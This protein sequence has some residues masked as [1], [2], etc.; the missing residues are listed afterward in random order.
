MKHVPKKAKLGKPKP[1]RIELDPRQLKAGIALPKIN[2]QIVASVEEEE[3]YNG[4]VLPLPR[5]LV[6]YLTRSELLVVA[7]I[8]EQSRDFGECAL[9]V[10]ELSARLRLSVPTMSNCLYSLRK[11]G[12]LLEMPDGKRGAGRIRKLNY[13]AIQHLNDLCEDEDYGIY[14]RIRKAT[15]KRDILNLTKEDIKKAYDNHI[16]EP[17]HDPAEEEEY[18]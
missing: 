1:I 16:L 9:T 7:T 3:V 5:V 13:K 11:I 8:F 15:R 6:Y 12:L 18:D 10:K 17:G 2:Y 14:T 4:M